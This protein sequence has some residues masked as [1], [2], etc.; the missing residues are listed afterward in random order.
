MA[1]TSTGRWELLYRGCCVSKLSSLRVS[2]NNVQGPR[3]AHLASSI[4]LPARLCGCSFWF[5][6]T[7]SPLT[8]HSQQWPL[9]TTQWHSTAVS[10]LPH[11]WVFH[12]QEFLPTVETSP[13]GLHFCCW[14]CKRNSNLKT[15]FFIY[16]K[17]NNARSCCSVWLTQAL[18]PHFQS[19]FRCKQSLGKADKNLCSRNRNAACL[20]SQRSL[21]PALSIPFGISNLFPT[22]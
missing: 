3:T 16:H 20:T 2:R 5:I 9:Q 8:S 15:F 6:Q 7:N 4:L 17:T 12:V 13:R 14:N 19:I 18:L 21:L 10:F 1:I 22:H 11:T